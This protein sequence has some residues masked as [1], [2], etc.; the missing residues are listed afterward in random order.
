M[1]GKLILVA[2]AALGLIA[3]E[4]GLQLLAWPSVASDSS[5]D[6]LL[7][8]AMISCA[9][10]YHTDAD[11]NC[12]PD[13]GYVDSRCQAGFEAAPFPNGNGYWC[14]PYPKDY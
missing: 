14:V 2:A 12:Q 8:L 5:V 7:K 10:G 11:G 3:A 13:N 9:G 4:I 6:N 1:F